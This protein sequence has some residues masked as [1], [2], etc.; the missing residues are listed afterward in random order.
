MKNADGSSC[1]AF[2]NMG[3]K[4]R[5]SWWLYKFDKGMC[6]E[7]VCRTEEESMRIKYASDSDNAGED[8]IIAGC[9]LQARIYPFGR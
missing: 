3:G 8:G 7:D 1:A 9:P 2:K 6:G 4:W 5:E